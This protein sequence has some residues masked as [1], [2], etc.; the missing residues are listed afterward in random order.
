MAQAA[1]PVIPLV[2]DGRGARHTVSATPL[3][4]C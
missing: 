4:T 3:S 1:E 2:L